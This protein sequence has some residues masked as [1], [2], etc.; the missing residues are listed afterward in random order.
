MTDLET[1]LQR[2][3]LQQYLDAFIAEGFETWETVLDI[4]EADLYVIDVKKL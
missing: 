1:L 2:L 3:G 4:Q